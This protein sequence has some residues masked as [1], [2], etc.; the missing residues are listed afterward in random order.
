M[1]K[2]EAN[3]ITEG[4]EEDI[5]SEVRDAEVV[6][7]E[8]QGEGQWVKKSVIDLSLGLEDYAASPVKVKKGTVDLALGLEYEKTEQQTKSSVPSSLLKFGLEKQYSNEYSESNGN[9]SAE[10]VKLSP[11][12]LELL[13]EANEAWE[14]KVDERKRLP[15]SSL[16]CLCLNSPLSEHFSASA[17]DMSSSD[18]LSKLGF[19]EGLESF[20]EGETW[21]TKTASGPLL[22]V[23]PSLSSDPTLSRL[24]PSCG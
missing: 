15:H 18:I 9:G 24:V 12:L 14:E 21:E 5:L 6:E 13:G 22:I 7:K 8:Q 4:Q 17:A 10:D 1:S 20:G 16:V 11:E 19:S 2:T 23:A 3:K